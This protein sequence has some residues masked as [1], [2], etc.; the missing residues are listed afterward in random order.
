MGILWNPQGPL[1]V[2][3]CQ[4]RPTCPLAAGDRGSSREDGGRDGSP[5]SPQAAQGQ[6]LGFTLGFGRRLPG[7]DRLESLGHDGLEFKM[8]SLK[9]VFSLLRS[10]LLEETAIIIW[11]RVSGQQ[12][13]GAG[14]GHPCTLLAA[15]GGQGHGR[16]WGRS[17]EGAGWSAHALCAR[18]GDNTPRSW[19]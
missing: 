5:Q 2:G 6:N 13:P 15:A 12:V 9:V 3:R 14:T 16:T 4:A 1:G 7:S 8:V 11:F 10:F 18:K 17:C 19:G